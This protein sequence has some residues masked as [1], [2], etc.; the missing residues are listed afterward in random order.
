MIQIVGR[1]CEKDVKNSRACGRINAFRTA[2]YLSL[3]ESDLCFFFALVI[4]L[5]W[6]ER[7]QLLVS[8]LWE[9][10]FFLFGTKANEQ[11]LSGLSLKTIWLKASALYCKIEDVQF[12]FKAC[13]E[14]KAVFVE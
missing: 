2:L 11:T 9:L 6:R 3:W 13:V 1:K 4:S 8:D 7:R 12:H 5:I 10:F 14:P